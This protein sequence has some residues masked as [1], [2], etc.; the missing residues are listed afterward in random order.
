MHPLAHLENQTLDDQQLADLRIQ[1]KADSSLWREYGD[2]TAWSRVKTLAHVPK[3]T[4]RYESIQS[5]IEHMRDELLEE[6]DSQL[7]CL[8]VEQ[9]ISCWL[10]LGNTSD[11]L[12]S[13][14][15]TKENLSEYRRLEQRYNHDQIRFTRVINLL[16]RTRKHMNEAA[17][18]K[19]RYQPVVI[20]RLPYDPTPLHLRKNPPESANKQGA[21][22]TRESQTNESTGNYD[23]MVT[24]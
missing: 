7:E 21:D 19:R 18:K 11:Q 6:G 23:K 22:S 17:A 2:I 20:K 4:L 13:L 16:S 5:G 3:R 1:L 12:E 10:Q 24:T 8:I 9:I 14:V 15:L